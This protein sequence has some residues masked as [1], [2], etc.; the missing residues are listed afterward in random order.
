MTDD[1]HFTWWVRDLILSR[2]CP[3]TRLLQRLCFGVRGIFFSGLRRSLV[4][5]WSTAS[6]DFG[7]LAEGGEPRSFHSAWFLSLSMLF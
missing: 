5:G 7:A 6:C 2:P 3:H 1:F 4:D